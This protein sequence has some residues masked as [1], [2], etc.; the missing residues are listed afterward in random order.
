[1]M[2]DLGGLVKWT[3]SQSIC[4]LE[5]IVAEEDPTFLDCRG[6]NSHCSDSADGVVFLPRKNQSTRGNLELASKNLV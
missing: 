3:A 4:A 2:V 1:M 6:W 5:N